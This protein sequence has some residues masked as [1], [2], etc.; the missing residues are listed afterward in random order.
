MNAKQQ[1]EAF[2]KS[3]FTVNDRDYE[4]CK[5]THPQR[6]KVFAYFTSIMQ[7]AN[8]GNFS[9]MDSEKF[10]EIEDLLCSLIKFDG[11]LIKV[12]DPNVHFRDYAED[13]LEFIVDSMGVISYPF[14]RGKT[15][16]SQSQ[17]VETIQTTS[18]KPMSL[19]K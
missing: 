1:K 17:E 8:I 7:D 13:Y 4:I 2:E 15:I 5:M 18:Q 3:M 16:S 10:K 9:F 14:F 6:R 12:L 11:N 19:L